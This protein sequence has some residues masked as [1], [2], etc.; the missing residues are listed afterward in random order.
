ME[1]VRGTAAYCR[2]RANVSEV[3]QP[4]QGR[5]RTARKT[6]G[7]SKRRYGTTSAVENTLRNK[8]W[9]PHALPKNAPAAS[10]AATCGDHPCPRH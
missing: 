5:A 1:I 8:T 2:R 4:T 6:T 3:V 7:A 10:R 9:R